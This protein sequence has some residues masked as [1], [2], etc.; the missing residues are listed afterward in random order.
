MYAVILTHYCGY[1][2]KRLVGKSYQAAVERGA[3][4]LAAGAV[5]YRVVRVRV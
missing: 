3:Q 2:S 1:K 5:S 4:A